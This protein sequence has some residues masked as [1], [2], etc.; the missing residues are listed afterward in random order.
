VKSH[1]EKALQEAVDSLKLQATCEMV[2]QQIE[3]LRQ[4]GGN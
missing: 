4:A 1:F 3:R 2:R